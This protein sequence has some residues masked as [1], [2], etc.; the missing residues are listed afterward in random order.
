[1]ERQCLDSRSL[2][3]LLLKKLLRS[4]CRDLSVSMPRRPVGGEFVFLQRAFL[5]NIF[6]VMIHRLGS[7]C[8]KR[9]PFVPG[10]ILG[11][12][13]HN[14]CLGSRGIAAKSVTLDFYGTSF[15]CDPVVP[16]SA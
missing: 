4:V 12:I 13:L 7:T 14:P 10:I 8:G 1:M 15:G 2:Q 3:K 9:M 6:G 5:V 16:D 11:E